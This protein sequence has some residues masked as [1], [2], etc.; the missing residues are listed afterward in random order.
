MDPLPHEILVPVFLDNAEEI[1]EILS[2]DKKRKVDIAMPQRGE[3]KN[4]LQMAY[5]NAEATFKKEKDLAEIRERTLLELQEKF[6]L[7]RYPRRIECFDN[8]NISGAKPV[9]S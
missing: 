5:L 1:A 9:L 3:K 7:T 2:A 8:S 4:L 6:R